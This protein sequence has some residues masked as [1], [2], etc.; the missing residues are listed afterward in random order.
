MSQRVPLPRPSRF[1]YPVATI[2]QYESFFTIVPLRKTHRSQPRT[3]I[4]SPS[5]VVPDKVHSDAPVTVNES[6]VLLIPDV[7]DAG[8]A[9][10]ERLADLIPA[11]EPGPGIRST[12]PFEDC[13]GGGRRAHRRVDGASMRRA[14]LGS[15]RA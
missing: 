12:R 14:H 6:L 10:G 13:V 5:V 4:R 15:T 1:C 11:N 8:E 9:G 2:F 7:G 3:S